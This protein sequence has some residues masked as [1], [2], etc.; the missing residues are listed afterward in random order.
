[1]TWVARVRLSP[2][3]P[4]L[5]DNRKRAPRQP[6]TVEDRVAEL[7]AAK[8][9]LADAVVGSGEAWLTELDDAALADLASLGVSP[10]ESR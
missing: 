6:G 4:A 8:R 2:T 1:M 7:L 10:G 3:P 5:S 9:E